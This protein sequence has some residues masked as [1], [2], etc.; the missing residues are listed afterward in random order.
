MCTTECG[1]CGSLQYS[2]TGHVAPFHGT[3]IDRA[4]E[5]VLQWY[6]DNITNLHN[7]RPSN[8]ELAGFFIRLN[9]PRMGVLLVLT[10]T[11]FVLSV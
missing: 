9:E 11:V 6:I 1:W 10:L 8:W 3:N 7:S 2:V 5:L 4:R